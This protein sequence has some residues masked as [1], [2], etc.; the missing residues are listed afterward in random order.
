M[1]RATG[2]ALLNDSG[3]PCLDGAD[4]WWADDDGKMLRNQN[5]HDLYLFAHG[6][7]YAAALRD[8]RTVGGAIPM[9]L[10]S[11]LGVMFSRWFDY[12]EEGVV[13][14]VG[15]FEQ[16]SLPLDALILDMNWHKKPGWTGYSWDRNLFPDPAA[17]TAWLRAKGLVVGAN[18]HD[19]QGVLP[20]E[21]TY[22]EV[23]RIMGV[24]PGAP[25]SLSLT[26]R[27]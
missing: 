10:R 3:A 11:Q 16:R 12:D 4:D 19:A 25:V 5:V 1:T 20:E 24:P 14:L 17:L 13:A 15:E 27:T 9:P 23:A 8:L 18:L 2:W 21:D 22:N 7:D 6:S 26:N